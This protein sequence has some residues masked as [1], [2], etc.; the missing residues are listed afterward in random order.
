[1]AD[2]EG[3]QL[4]CRIITPE[5]VIFDGEVDR[6]IVRIGDGDIGVLRDHAPV[7][8]TAHAGAVR[9]LQDDETTVYAISD[10]FFKVSEN[11]VQVLV[12][13][14][15]VPEDVNVDELESR[16]E[17]IE[18]EMSESSEDGEDFERRQREAERR[19]R[20]AESIIHVA[21]EHGEG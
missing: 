10:G 9:V 1:M 7:I 6:V 5:E 4:F 13:E 3:R 14:A 20:A 21:R 15:F 2:D 8:S 19:Q 12:E 16:I 11:L 17:E 18:R